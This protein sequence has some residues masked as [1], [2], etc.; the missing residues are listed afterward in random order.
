MIAKW[1]VD[2]D[3]HNDKCYRRPVCPECNAP[4]IRYEDGMY[5]CLSCGEIIEV[6]GDDM[7]EWIRVR[8]ETK[9]EYRDCPRIENKGK[10]LKMGCGGK[11]CVKTLFRRN[12][13][14]LEWEIAMGECTQCG[15]KYIVQEI[16]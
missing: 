5:R 4:I 7:K 1:G 11:N 6:A 9:I 2:Y 15:L 14:T 12:Q 10:F 13:V 16:I 3:Y 8:E